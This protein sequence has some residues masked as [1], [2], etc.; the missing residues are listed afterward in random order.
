M[1]AVSSNA[2]E[3]GRLDP[4]VSIRVPREL[5]QVIDQAVRERGAW[6]L[7]KRGNNRTFWILEAI[8]MRIVGERKSS[9]GQA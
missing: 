1:A 5:L 4:V 8:R 3:H 7:G 6:H 9:N 2:S